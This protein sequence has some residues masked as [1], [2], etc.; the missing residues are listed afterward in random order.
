[1]VD[2]KRETY[3]ENGIEKMVY[4]GTIMWLN[5]KIKEKWSDCKTC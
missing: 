3:E 5:E 1:M 4:S 2:T